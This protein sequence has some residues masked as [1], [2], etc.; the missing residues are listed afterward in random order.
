MNGKPSDFAAVVAAYDPQDIGSS[1]TTTDYADLEN[2]DSA[3]CIV[4][5]GANGQTGASV[6]SVL[7]ASDSTGS[8]SAVVQSVSITSSASNVQHVFNVETEDLTS[9]NSHIAVKV[10]PDGDT[11]AT[12]VSVLILGQEARYLPASDYD[13]SS[14]TIN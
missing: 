13:A 9:G 10:A 1:T 2:F 5:I 7:S 3:Q 12:L 11:G 14:V 6:V 8:D 4:S